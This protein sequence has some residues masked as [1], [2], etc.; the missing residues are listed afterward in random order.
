MRLGAK[1]EHCAAVL[2]GV[3]RGRARSG[4]RVTC[5]FGF[6]AAGSSASTADSGRRS[7]RHPSAA[8]QK[9]GPPLL[10][11]L[12]TTGLP[13]T[14]S[15]EMAVPVSVRFGAREG[16][17]RTAS[18]FSAKACRKF[19]VVPVL[20]P[21]S[22]NIAGPT[23]PAGLV[24]RRTSHG[25]AFAAPDWQSRAPV[26]LDSLAG[27]VRPRART[28]RRRRRAGARHPRRARAAGPDPEPDATGPTP[29]CPGWTPWPRSPAS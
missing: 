15:T 26:G 6:A 5:G 17:R 20:P 14:K 18:A 21:D 29:G 7:M 19:G 10:R 25:P 28:V 12:P 2:S 13:I 9:S 8:T 11:S 24:R 27:L 3:R 22:T 23:S 4:M 1:W 16:A